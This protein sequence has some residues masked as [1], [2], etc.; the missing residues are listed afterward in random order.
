MDPTR[1]DGWTRR[2]QSRRALGLTLVSVGLG[3]GSA[4]QAVT[5][6]KPAKTG[7]RPRL[8][9]TK[10]D[11][12][13]TAIANTLCPSAPAE[14]G[15]SCV[16]DNKGR[17]FCAGTGACA[18]CKKNRDC[19]TLGIGPGVLCV[20]KCPHCKNQLGGFSTA[21]LAPLVA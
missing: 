9:C 13:C 8:G 17:P 7:T 21:C 11:N 1:F 6:P 16:N 12:T 18:P 19:A 3:F 4:R 10:Q 15:A 2:L 20:K 5:A 14:S